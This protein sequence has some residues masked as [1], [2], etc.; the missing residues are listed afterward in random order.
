MPVS[1]PIFRSMHHH[2]HEKC[3]TSWNRL[4]SKNRAQRAKSKKP[5]KALLLLLLASQSSPWI[6]AHLRKIGD[7]ASCGQ[8]R[9]PTPH[10]PTSWAAVSKRWA[11]G[12]LSLFNSEY[13]EVR[14]SLDCGVCSVSSRWK[15]W[16]RYIRENAGLHP[17][18]WHRVHPNICTRWSKSRLA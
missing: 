16:M 7:F 8:G 9:P 14:W 11:S 6:R 18:N 5:N 13:F 10:R 12:N 2:K 17:K 15:T 1:Q 3:S 4:R